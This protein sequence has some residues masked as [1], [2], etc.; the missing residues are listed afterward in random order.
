MKKLFTVFSLSVCA[1]LFSCQKEISGEGG[2]PAPVP[3]S[4]KV[5]S[6][7]YYKENVGVYDSSAFVYNGDKVITA[8]SDIKLVTYSYNGNN[9]SGRTYYDKEWK[10]MAFVDSADYDAN[11]RMTRLRV[12]IYPGRFSTESQQYTYVFNYNGNNLDRINAI[13]QGETSASSADT[14][15]NV[16]HINDA[17]NIESIAVSDNAGNLYDSVRYTYDNNPNYFKKINPNFFLFDAN[18]QLEGNY[19]HHLPYCMSKNNVTSFSYFAN[20]VYQVGY[21]TDSLKNVTAV[22]VNGAPYATYSYVCH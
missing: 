18:F 20:T 15:N 7:Y 13:H 14:L 10:L 3:P 19:L 12:W 4:C 8:E 21:Q 5:V 6:A 1:I 17:G 16:F 2:D 22:N 9:I 11:N